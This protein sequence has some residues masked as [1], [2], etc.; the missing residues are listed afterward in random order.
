MF[1]HNPMKWRGL[2]RPFISVDKVDR[3]HAITEAQS[4]WQQAEEHDFVTAHEKLADTMILN[5]TQLDACDG[6]WDR[7]RVADADS[8]CYALVAEQDGEAQ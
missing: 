5:R 4:A 6:F 7:L 3:T 1:V 2:V 8:K